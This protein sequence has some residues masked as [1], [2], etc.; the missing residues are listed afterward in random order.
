MCIFLCT[1]GSTLGDTIVHSWLHSLD[2]VR[3][4]LIFKVI[5]VVECAY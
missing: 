4:V 2:N 3:D 5:Q 1:L